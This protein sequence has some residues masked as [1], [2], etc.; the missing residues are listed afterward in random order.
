MK[1]ASYSYGGYFNHVHGNMLCLILTFQLHLNQSFSAVATDLLHPH[2]FQRRIRSYDFRISLATRWTK[3]LQYLVQRMRTRH[4]GG[5]DW[6]MGRALN[7]ISPWLHP[8]CLYDLQHFDRTVQC[9]DI[10][11]SYTDLA[12]AAASDVE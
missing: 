2:S 5:V 6:A 1:I 11:E 3:Q 7:R 8:T 4:K 12:L 9:F 10:L